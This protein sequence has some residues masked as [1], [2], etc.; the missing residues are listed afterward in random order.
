MSPC[1]LFAY[2]IIELFVTNIHKNYLP[3]RTKPLFLNFCIIQN[4]LVAVI[5]P[6]RST[7]CTLCYGQ[8]ILVSYSSHVSARVGYHQVEHIKGKVDTTSVYINNYYVK[9]AAILECKRRIVPAYIVKIYIKHPNIPQCMLF[10][11][12]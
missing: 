4:A 12:C 9:S 7:Q 5:L 2:C 8:Q 1:H 11:I 10:I 6:Q 3:C